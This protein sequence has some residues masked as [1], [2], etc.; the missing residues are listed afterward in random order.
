MSSL[1]DTTF[2]FLDA[3]SWSPEV[4]DEAGVAVEFQGD[5]GVWFCFAAILEGLERV[6]FYSVYPERIHEDARQ[7]VAELFTLANFGLLIGNF[8]IDLFDGEARFRT[9]I[10]VEGAKLSDALLR[11][12]IYTNVATMDYL[13]PTI[14]AVASRNRS[15]QEAWAAVAPA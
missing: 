10:D 2:A 11:Q 9:S 15:A 8:E 13:F 7:A 4:H 12:L 3:D 6:I 14:G 1:L 5:N